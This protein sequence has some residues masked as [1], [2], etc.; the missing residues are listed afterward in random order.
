MT[1]FIPTSRRDTCE[2][3]SSALWGLALPA[4]LRPS[5]AT[6]SMFGHVTCADGS[7]WIECDPA[8]SILVHQEAELDGIADILQPWIN[9]GALPTDTNTVLT[10]FIESKRGQ[11][12]TVWDA[13][14]Q[15]FKDQSK[16]HQ[17][18]VNLGL[19]AIPAES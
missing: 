9:E 11:S 10:A 13:F 15:F 7:V 14:P 1:R 8:F 5:G 4:S 17:E 2:R 19:L 16:T 18:L 12:L 3:L 6:D